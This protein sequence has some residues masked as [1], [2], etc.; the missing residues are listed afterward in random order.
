MVKGAEVPRVFLLSPAVGKVDF[1]QGSIFYPSVLRTC[2]IK[3]SL[4]S[5]VIVPFQ[6]QNEI[7]VILCRTFDGPFFLG[8]VFDWGLREGDAS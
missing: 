8:E 3:L 1:V 7:L 6:N 4:F 5:I 2:R